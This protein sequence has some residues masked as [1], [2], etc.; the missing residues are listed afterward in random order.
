VVGAAL[1]LV[2]TLGYF[3][4]RSVPLQMVNRL[5]VPIGVVVGSEAERRVSPGDSGALIVRAL[6]IAVGELVRNRSAIGERPG[7]RQRPATH[8]VLDSR[9][10]ALRIEARADSGSARPCSCRTSPTR[11]VSRSHCGST[12][13][14]RPRSRAG[15]AC[16]RAPCACRSG[17]FP[18]YRN[19]SVRAILPNGRIATFEG[20]GSQVNRASGVCAAAI[21][22]EGLPD[23]DGVAGRRV[24]K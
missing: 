13:G 12:S 3:A 7:R 11:R 16:R 14:R 19:S 9:Q 22:R 5:S 2:T 24:S 1:V 4:N 10:R 18:L 23:P 15:A 17:Y 8:Q 21:R 20:L 6:A